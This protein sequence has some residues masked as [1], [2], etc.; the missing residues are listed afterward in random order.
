LFSPDHGEWAQF[1]VGLVTGF[2]TAPYSWGILWVIIFLILWEILF[3]AHTKMSPKWWSP[4]GR[5]VIVLGYI[6]GWIMG[7]L[8]VGLEPFE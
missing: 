4:V 5:A 3:A 1:F 8:F 6:F 7:R 2:V